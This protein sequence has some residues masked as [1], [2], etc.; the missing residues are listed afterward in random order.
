MEERTF[1]VWENGKAR[2]EEEKSGCML[3]YIPVLLIQ[4]SVT[5]YQSD[6]SNDR[7]ASNDSKR[8]D[9]LTEEES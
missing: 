9:G 6:A 7:G 1:G 8:T 4:G 3:F 5:L 2:G